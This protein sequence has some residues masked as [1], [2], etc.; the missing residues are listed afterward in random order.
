MPATRR[1]TK[2]AIVEDDEVLKEVSQHYNFKFGPGDDINEVTWFNMTSKDQTFEEAM[3]KLI[4]FFNKKNRKAKFKIRRVNFTIDSFNTKGDTILIDVDGGPMEVKKVQFKWW[5]TGKKTTLMV[6]NSAGADS[7]HVKPMLIV[8]KYLLHGFL[9][10]ELNKKTLDTFIVS[11]EERQTPKCEDCGAE[12]TSIVSP[13]I[14]RCK[15]EATESSNK[16]STVQNNKV[17]KED[18]KAAVEE[19]SGKERFKDVVSNIVELQVDSGLMDDPSLP[20]LS[21]PS[22][23]AKE[24]PIV[25]KVPP[26]GPDAPKIPTDDFLK[27]NL[28][29]A[30]IADVDADGTCA[31]KAYSLVIFGTVAHWVY[32]ARAMG[33]RVAE[34]WPQLKEN[35]FI[36][37]ESYERRIR[38]EDREYKSDESLLKFLRDEESVHGW[39][40]FTD[41]WA[42]SD[43]LG[44]QT[45][46]IL[47]KDG[48]LNGMITLGEQYQGA[49]VILLFDER[50]K[51]YKA[52]INPDNVS[53]NG[54]LFFELKKY[55][56]KMTSEKVKSE[57]EKKLDRLLQKMEEYEEELQKKTN[58]F[59]EMEK[60]ISAYEV[61][62]NEMK[63]EI[64]DMKRRMK[65]MEERSES[66]PGEP[67]PQAPPPP[68][69]VVP[70]PAVAQVNEVPDVGSQPA[71]QSDMEISQPDDEEEQIRTMQS[72][73][74][75]GSVRQCP[76][77]EAVK[78]KNFQCDP[79]KCI[80]DSE[81]NLKK[82]KVS[83]HSTF[84][85]VVINDTNVDLNVNKDR[86]ED[87]DVS[88]KVINNSKEDNE[89][90]SA[91]AGAFKVQKQT[92]AL[93][94]QV[95]K[96]FNDKSRQYN[97]KDC[98]FQG[99]S[100]KNLVMHLKESK[101]CKN[102][103]P[104]IEKCYTCGVV[105][106]N[107]E[108]LM[109]HRKQFHFDKINSCRY[110]KEDLCKFKSSCW[111]KHEDSVEVSSVGNVAPQNSQDF[112]VEAETF[113]PDLQQLQ[114]ITSQFTQS[115]QIITMQ[116]TKQLATMFQHSSG[117]RQNVSPGA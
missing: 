88:L 103:D 105:L 115:M 14:H 4:A 113:P 102:T 26:P 100:S 33:L 92:A 35:G 72:W 16:D 1:K 48:Y 29:K 114:S 11:V 2:A 39:K 10:N 55:I 66:R 80:F 49:K 45:Q 25:A 65:I 76:Q 87:N 73:R 112:Q 95:Q 5:L 23:P 47:S 44:V 43:L 101:T 117:G 86:K 13:E 90:I 109:E 98:P 34:K 82:H 54:K 27:K 70:P 46:I 63:M 97:C 22:S 93:D 56:T 91:T 40:D 83:M 64:E 71:S 58:R 52:I 42:L 78:K 61:E 81:E 51:H 62:N 12:F 106:E 28:P 108:K 6:S 79:C 96:L 41:F 84:K 57:S 31:A 9:D 20:P 67:H 107:F 110:Q 32:V 19:K 89:E 99:T 75:Q 77:E 21:P 17:S 68:A 104:L 59:E 74:L 8:I 18:A 94:V 50:A 38:G 60:K 69:E 7:F 15:N 53:K 37:K 85:K 111:Y 36:T 116:F 30:V 3:K 24:L